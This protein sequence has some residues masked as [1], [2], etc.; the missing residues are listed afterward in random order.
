MPTELSHHCKWSSKHSTQLLFLNF[1]P[2][3]PPKARFTST[4]LWVFIPFL[5]SNWEPIVSLL[6]LFRR[7]RLCDP[8]DCSPPGSTVRGVL[9]AR[10]VEWVAMPSS[11][12]SSWARDWTHVSY[13]SGRLVLYHWKALLFS[14]AMQILLIFTTISLFLSLH[15]IGHYNFS[16]YQVLEE[17]LIFCLSQ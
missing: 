9:Q 3:Q 16:S 11:R 1:L 8:A 4:F 10:I 6:S 2:Q 14:I 12:G 17:D 15:L 5:S 7:V 13:I